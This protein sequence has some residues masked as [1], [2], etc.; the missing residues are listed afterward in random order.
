MRAVA[1]ANN[2]LAI[3]LYRNLAG[4]TGNL[5]FSPLGAT[6][7][8]ALLS[9]GSAGVTQQQIIDAAHIS[10]PP[11]DFL[12]GLSALNGRLNAGSGGCEVRI[13]NRLWVQAGFSVKDD[14]I[15]ASRSA[16]GEEPG[17]IDFQDAAA[18]R[19][20]VNRWGAEQTNGRITE[21]LAP[22]SLTDTTRFIVT[23]GTHFKGTWKYKF[24]PA[25]TVESPF[26]LAA[27]SHVPVRMMH[28][29]GAMQ[30]GATPEMQ[31][32]ELPYAGGAMSMLILL[33]KQVDGLAR[34][35]ENLSPDALGKWLSRLSE[36][37]EVEVRLPK[38][39]FSSE[40]ALKESLVALGM[41]RAFSNDA[42]FPGISSEKS[43]KLFDAVQQTFVDVNEAGTEAAAVTGFIGGDAPSPV[44]Q[45]ILFNADHPF[46][47]LIRDV[48]SGAI[49]FLGRVVHPIESSRNGGVHPSD[50]SRSM[51]S[52]DIPAASR[53]ER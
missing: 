23:N 16:F 49:L 48:P 21:I 11:A 51:N 17:R 3:D 32:L 34:L 52:G 53:G 1:E 8:L 26:H 33:P 37:G 40:A 42:E 19:E 25:A 44:P 36:E 7:G 5:C 38:F 30:Y 10:H 15:R 18:A 6:A 35:E 41:Q 14:F 20:V 46:L 28:Q 4:G 27:E 24:D 13:A 43:E 47:F 9:S 50:S 2:A 29:T 12:Q 45:H 22:G 31:I 39:T